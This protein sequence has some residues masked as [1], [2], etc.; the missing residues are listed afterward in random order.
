MPITVLDLKNDVTTAMHGTSLRVCSDINNTIKNAA[1]QM[2]TRIDVRSTKRTTPIVNAVYDKIWD[3]ICPADV[4][5]IIDLQPQSIER[6]F[7]EDLSERYTKQFDIY[8]GSQYGHNMIQINYSNAGKYLRIS[9]D[10]GR[11]NG[12]LDPGQLYTSDI[13]TWVGGVD[14]TDVKNNPLNFI[15]GNSAI[16]FNLDGATQQGYI[17]ISFNN[18]VDLASIE[19]FGSF[20]TWLFFPDADAITSVVFEFGQ[21]QANKWSQTI[22]Q[23]QAQLAF[24]DGW[25][26]LRADWGIMTET[27]SPSASA[28]DYVR[29]TINYNG[30]EQNALIYNG[31]TAKFGKTYNLVYYSEYLFRDPTTNEWILEPLDDDTIINVDPL[32]Y[33]ILLNETCR[34]V[35][36]EAKGRNMGPDKKFFE[37][38]L[39]GNGIPR[40]RPGARMGLYESYGA[41]YPSEAL[42]G[43]E[44]Y[45]EYGDFFDSI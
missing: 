8:K 39:F 4:K 17:E 11:F 44:E 7:W 13:G 9:K 29:L 34:L 43:D 28:I 14:A 15:Q 38:E 41:Q 35:A 36:Q 18:P 23:Q 24:V 19:D 33:T 1:F 20:F 12:V 32:A 26:L 22:L 25:N 30:T 42:N 31:I 5:K 2:L 37:E 10:V 45:Y 3:Y 27:G 21:D 6:P 40:E 16:Q